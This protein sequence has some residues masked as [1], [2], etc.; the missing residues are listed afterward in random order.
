MFHYQDELIS[1][2]VVEFLAAEG[3]EHWAQALYVALKAFFE[4][5]LPI[6][7]FIADLSMVEPKSQ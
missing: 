1:P 5:N 7:E 6:K 4:A 2:K 3:S